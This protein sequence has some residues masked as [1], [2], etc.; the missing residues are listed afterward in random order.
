MKKNHNLLLLFLFCSI[1][2]A[3]NGAIYPVNNTSDLT[4]VLYTAYP[5]P[6]PLLVPGDIIQINSDLNVSS[7]DLPIIIPTGIIVQGN[8][9]LLSE[10]NSNG[11]T[12]PEGTMIYSNR[13]SNLHTQDVE[14][15]YIF[16]LEP[17]L[18]GFPTTLR[19]IR[20]KGPSGN[21]IDYNNDFNGENF[22]SGGVYLDGN[23]GGYIVS[24][25]EIL[26]FSYSGIFGEPQ[27]TDIQIK[28]CYIHNI[29]GF[30]DPGIG[31]AIWLQNSSLHTNASIENTIFN[32]CKEAID[33]QSGIQDWNINNCTMTQFFYGGIARHNG[34]VF[35][36]HPPSPT[37]GCMYFHRSQDVLEPADQIFYV[38]DI[39]GGNTNI[40]GMISHFQLADDGSRGGLCG[41]PYPY[42]I[43]LTTLQQYTDI[44]CT[45]PNPPTILAQGGQNLSIGNFQ[46]DLNDGGWT[47]IPLNFT[48]NFFNQPFT[49]CNISTNGFIQFGNQFDYASTGE[50]I[51]S[52]AA[53]NNFIA[54]CMTDLD[55][56]YIP[57]SPGYAGNP[58]GTIQYCVTGSSP[59]Q[60]FQVEWSYGQHANTSVSGLLI[61]HI[62]IF[63]ATGVIQ[64]QI[65]RQ[66]L[67]INSQV[68]NIAKLAGIEDA[69]GNGLAALNFYDWNAGLSHLHYEFGNPQL[70]S[71]TLSGNTLASPHGTQYQ[72]NYGGYATIA[73]NYIESCPW[74]GDSKIK[75]SILTGAAS[76]NSFDYKPNQ[77]VNYATCPQPPEC[78]LELT[79][80]LGNVIERTKINSQYNSNGYPYISSGTPFKI[81]ISPGSL[82]S[83]NNAYR[84]HFNPEH[85]LAI[86]NNSSGGN[87]YFEDS[88]TIG[89]ATGP[90]EYTYSSYDANMPG[91]HGLDVLA[92]A[93]D[94]STSPF[95]AKNQSSAWQHIPLISKPA[96]GE[97]H[98]IFNIKDSYYDQYTPAGNQQFQPTGV[99]KTVELNGHTIWQEDIAEGGDGWE[100]VDI[101]FQSINPE[102]IIPSEFGKNLLSFSIN[103]NQQN[104]VG[105]VVQGV[106]VWIDDVY[107]NRYD[108][109]KGTNL[110]VD[111]DIENMSCGVLPTT[112]QNCPNGDCIDECSWF[113]NDKNATGYP[114]ICQSS[115]SIANDECYNDGSPLR[116]TQNQ[117]LYDYKCDAYLSGRDRKSGQTSIVLNLPNLLLSSSC[118]SYL[119]PTISTP[120]PS[121]ELPIAIPFASGT[122]FFPGLVSAFTQFEY[123]RCG[124]FANDLED[125]FSDLSNADGNFSTD[126]NLNHSIKV[127]N[128]SILEF[129]NSTLAIGPGVSI[130]VPNGSTLILD[131]SI[132]SACGE[133]MWRGI[134]VEQGGTLQNTSSTISDAQFGIQ[135][136]D[137][138]VVHVD[139][140]TFTNNYIGIDFTSQGAIGAAFIDAIVINSTFQSTT[141]KAPYFGQTPT[142]LSHSFKGINID[143]NTFINI[144]D[145]ATIDNFFSGLNYGIVSLNSSV[146][147]QHSVFRDIIKYDNY[148]LSIPTIHHPQGTAII[149]VGNSSNFININGNSFS[150]FEFQN[151]EYGIRVGKMNIDCFD[152]NADNCDIGMEVSFQDHCTS[153]IHNNE[154]NC[155][156]YGI[157]AGLNDYASSFSI[158]ENKIDVGSRLTINGSIPNAIA[159]SVS[160]NS[161]RNF[162]SIIKYNE[163]KLHDFA[164]H[165]IFANAVSGY[166]IDHNYINMYNANSNLTG[167]SLTQGRQCTLNCNSISGTGNVFTYDPQ[168]AMWFQDS[169]ENTISC[170]TVQKTY[171][172]IGFMGTCIGGNGTNLHSNDI[173]EHNIGIYYKGTATRVDE[174]R[175][176]GNSWYFDNYSLYGAWDEDLTWAAFD[177]YTVDQTGPRFPTGSALTNH[178]TPD[179]NQNISEVWPLTFVQ[180]ANGSDENCG[181]KLLPNEI[182]CGIGIGG[183]N[184]ESDR[185]AALNMEGSQDFDDETKWKTRERL[186]EKLLYEPN[187]LDSDTVFITFFQQMASSYLKQI[188]QLNKNKDEI[189]LNS[190]SLLQTISTR[191][192]QINLNTSQIAKCDSLSNLDGISTAVVDS[193]KLA[194]YNIVQNTSQLLNQN[195]ADLAL[196]KT[197]KENRSDI[198][199]AD[200]AIINS[201][202]IYEQNEKEINEAYLQMIYKDNLE[203]LPNFS[204]QILSI[205][206]QCP[207]SGGPAVY[208]ARTLAALIDPQLRYDDQL[209]CS[210]AGVSW[211]MSKPRS[212]SAMSVYPNPAKDNA[213]IN[214]LISNDALLIISNK[215]G[216]II[217]VESLSKESLNTVIELTNFKNGVY[218]C[219]L[220]QD[221]QVDVA[222]LIVIH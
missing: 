107:I 33:G 35:Y 130:T 49:T 76:E 86:D 64:L 190:Q 193:L 78:N 202:K 98:L 120:P 46:G 25:C 71:I 127:K 149:A 141:L 89:P 106:S 104:V 129:H 183:G 42:S 123:P 199:N 79:D 168:A 172:G 135:A 19:N 47:N 192:L 212:E 166:T 194:R 188:A 29:K 195:N 205:A 48:F 72:N 162:N 150:Q 67:N 102:W 121:T 214:Y 30:C 215:I 170:N 36:T 65:Y 4:S 16:K 68:P 132:L 100:R 3:S 15:F 152:L 12:S 208:K 139:N 131:Q 118:T 90:T 163:I 39:A 75:Y 145:G 217:R 94:N 22:Q 218:T 103:F 186:Y 6:N 189:Y 177:K 62:K 9:D 54:L 45:G 97:S 143:N 91:L 61:G 28:N 158:F 108:H 88:K 185:R 44:D 173:G 182:T 176:K 51:P 53:P 157:L 105:T 167:I 20:I 187:Y 221:G 191:T 17:G 219:K 164:Q 60:V 18:V 81:A 178:P 114:V 109:I 50:L 201:S 146:N 140:G 80:L 179:A 8:F 160:G 31:Y 5:N 203:L 180:D 43:P 96:Y 156:S 85:G 92:I 197:A 41:F 161:V 125:Q 175:Y 32:D 181:H 216:E 58:G 24:N 113:I 57:P 40:S 23:S 200:N 138:T 21:W 148:L 122:G 220:V 147:I 93:A 136:Q 137:A 52:L 165:G 134:I 69:S 37:G 133:N 83:Q 196:V 207:L 204:S 38:N 2:L 124:G 112:L 142:P 110:I 63:E 11:A 59:N 154:L 210:Q 77:S 7:L 153:Q 159:I 73:D 144:G 115:T 10:S 117:V 155:N 169:P 87:S 56:N 1:S 174:Q 26:N 184:G 116:R 111:G 128:G 126:F 101:P 211:R 13:R 14:S 70:F 171:T 119:N 198:L 95:W 99:L 74:A 222:Q 82:G 206:S 66:T 209:A 213:T 55:F 151:C 84:I 27:S 34:N